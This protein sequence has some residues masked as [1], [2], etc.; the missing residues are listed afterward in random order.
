MKI[1]R[2]PNRILIVTERPS[3]RGLGD[4]SYGGD[5]FKA[6]FELQSTTFPYIG[7][8]GDQRT[9]QAIA[10]AMHGS[11]L[12]YNV[13]VYSTSG[14]LNS[15][16]TVEGFLT[17]GYYTSPYQVQSA[18]TEVVNRTLRNAQVNPETWQ[19]V[20]LET[21]KEEG[22]EQVGHVNTQPKNNGGGGGGNR[23]GDNKPP[24]E[25]SGLDNLL[26]DLGLKAS[27]KESVLSTPSSM[28]VGAFALLLTLVVINKVTR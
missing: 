3:R 23:N 4:V 5:Y 2:Q 13:S 17:G 8:H 28:V 20:D 25:C 11:G 26:V 27:C 7:A 1:I 9:W 12:F 6:G 10:D 15:W 14:W 21:H 24:A 18:I 19:W 16:V 22:G